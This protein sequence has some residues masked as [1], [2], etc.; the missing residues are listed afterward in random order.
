MPKRPNHPCAAWPGALRLRLSIRSI[1]A[2]SLRSSAPYSSAVIRSGS[3]SRAATSCQSRS[4]AHLSPRR[5]WASASCRVS[6]KTSCRSL[7]AAKSPAHGAQAPGRG[8]L[9]GGMTRSVAMVSVPAMEPF[10]HSSWRW[11]SGRRG[12]PW[13]MKRIDRYQIA[14]ELGVSGRGRSERGRGGAA[15]G[16][17]TGPST[18]PLPTAVRAARPGHPTVAAAP[19]LPW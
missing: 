14:S 10:T 19:F 8:P 1:S 12:R 17:G 9:P 2:V 11:P 5:N 16:P 6:R 15:S 13:L 7:R 3:I 18:A 4:L